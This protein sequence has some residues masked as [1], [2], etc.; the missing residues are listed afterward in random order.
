[1]IVGQAHYQ[2]KL[3]G[4]NFKRSCDAIVPNWHPYPPEHIQ[5]A[6]SPVKVLWIAN[7][8]PSKQPKVFIRLA[9]RL[10]QHV[11]A[12]FIMAGRAGGRIYQRSVEKML[13]RASQIDYRG[14]LRM[15]DVNALLA[16]SHILV[17]T[18]QYEGFSNTFIQAWMRGVPVV[19]LNVDP[20]DVIARYGL[21]YHSHTFDRLCMDTRRLIQ[22]PQLRDAMG[23][24][25]RKYAFEN[26]SLANLSAMTELFR[27]AALSL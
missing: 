15:A 23:E 17:S 9:A 20:D 16:K 5:R 8:K 22:D 3:L 24:A 19:S 1:V 26:H 2:D 14:E 25:A 18:S 13:A 27:S 4:Q 12:S 7:I 11:E 21:G 10:C 6:R